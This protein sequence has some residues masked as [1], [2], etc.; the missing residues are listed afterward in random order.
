MYTDEDFK[1]LLG[2]NRGH[3]TIES[4]HRILDDSNT[5]HEDHL[6]IRTGH[7]HGKRH[8]TSPICDLGDQTARRI[9]PTHVCFWIIWA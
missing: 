3:W 1:S 8:G 2:L 9:R 7:G 6:L 5:W 4:N